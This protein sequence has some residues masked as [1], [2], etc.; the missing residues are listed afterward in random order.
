MTLNEDQRNIIIDGA[1]LSTDAI[2]GRLIGRQEQADR[3]RACL[4][5]MMTGQRPMNAWLHGPSGSGKTLLA[6]STTGEVCTSGA[7]RLAVY[8][9]CW[10]HRTQYSVLQAI[11]DELRILGA[12]AQDTNIKLDRIRQFLRDRPTVIILDEIDR[13]M[14]AVREEIIHAL[15]GLPKTGVV[16]VAG[17]TNALAAMEEGT[18]SRLSP[19]LIEAPAY[20]TMELEAILTDRANRSLSPGSWSP[21]TIRHIA[22]RSSGDARV[23][24]NALR[25]SAGEAEQSGQPKIDVRFIDHTLAQWQTVRQEARF[26]GLSEHEKIIHDL[27]KQHAPLG[28]TDLGRLYIAHCRSH[29]L[30]PIARRTFSKYLG[31]LSSAGLLAMSGQHGSKGGRMVRAA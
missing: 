20:S 21:A 3:L 1:S 12:E 8:V 6:R 9:N 13:P 25:R 28:A 19:A 17:S 31:R 5:P 22:L 16:C 18:R 23:A 14:P 30:H 2:P 15:L 24:I 10:R 11:I 26:V 29:G 7:N 27:A 4:A